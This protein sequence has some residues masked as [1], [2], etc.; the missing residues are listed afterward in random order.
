[1]EEEATMTNDIP[2]PTD[3]RDPET[4]DAGFVSPGEYAP[5]GEAQGIGDTFSAEQLA[6]AFRVRIGRVHDAM[7]GEYDL[8]PADQITSQ[9]ASELLEALL[10]EAPLDQR[11][12]MLMELGAFTPRGDV[13]RGIGESSPEEVRARNRADFADAGNPDGASEDE[14]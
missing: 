14:T 2:G 3:G 11:Q 10:P 12:A 1:M 13:E 7:R 9:Q 4:P 8:G 5:A 6:D